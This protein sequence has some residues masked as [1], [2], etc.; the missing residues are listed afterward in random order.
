[1]RQAQYEAGRKDVCRYFL[2]IKVLIPY[3]FERPPSGRSAKHAQIYPADSSLHKKTFVP[4]AFKGLPTD[5]FPRW[6][7]YISHTGYPDAIR[8]N[9]KSSDS[10][11]V[12]PAFFVTMNQM[13]SLVIVPNRFAMACQ[14]YRFMLHCL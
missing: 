2:K 6:E 12:F 14:R 8:Y 1:M 4:D 13:L 3:P 7:G 5:I 9:W 10:K 11:Q